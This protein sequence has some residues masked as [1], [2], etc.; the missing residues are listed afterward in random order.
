MI[1]N[2]ICALDIGSSK[3]SACLA[4]VK[5]GRAAEIFF[6]SLPF[7]GLTKGQ[8]IDSIGLVNTIG[9]VIK[10]LKSKSRL[11]VKLIYVN[12]SGLDISTKHSYAIIPLAERGN[13]II[14]PQDVRDV[15]EQ[16]LILGS[17]MVEEVVHYIP[18]GY[19]L[20]NRSGVVNPLGLYSHKLGVDLYL[21][22]AKLSA[23]QNITHAVNQAGYEVK[24]IIFSGLAT[25]KA[26]LSKEQG[27][28]N[29]FCD[30]GRDITELLIFKDGSLIDTHI[31]LAGG[32]DLSRALAQE[33]MIPLELAEELKKSHGSV[34]DNIDINED[35]E[36]L[37]KKED[38]YKPIKQKLICAILTKK[39]KS[40]C[41]IIKEY[42]LKNVNVVEVNSFI[43]TGRGVLLEGFLELL[44]LDTGLSA[45]L[46]R[47]SDAELLSIVSKSDILT[48]HKY[49]SYIT[50]LGILGYALR[51]KKT[52]SSLCHGMESESNV[53][54]KVVSKIKE[55][56]Q[57][58]F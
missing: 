23:V 4:R 44:D 58:Y 6:E 42:I 14:S 48:E 9:T 24:E 26:L 2:Y 56:Y 8:V 40:F 5:N 51:L 20:D 10:N 57:E 1:N 50:S 28:I 47:I 55:I 7:N 30:I 15:N 43:V 41:A 39:A 25:G 53:F 13:K 16:A 38:F 22:C 54:Q 49:I 37:V 46:G 11:T 52:P 19:E 33:L 29:I 18:Y 3:I 45:K 17:N 27:G 12:I 21:I 35:K 32:D 34:G 36:V 31:F